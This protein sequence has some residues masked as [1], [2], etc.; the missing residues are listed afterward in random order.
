MPAF[1]HHLTN[2]VSFSQIV[3]S[4]ALPAI[5]LSSAPEVSNSPSGAKYVA[6]F[7]KG[8]SGSVQFASTEDGQVQVSVNLTGLPDYGGP[9][10]YH[11]HEAPVP[12]DGNCTGT[13]KHLN[14][15][16]GSE[17]A[18]AAEDKE[19]GDL[20]GKHGEIDG[21]ELQTTY[22]D[23]YLSLNK[24]DPAYF[25]NLSVVVHLH[26]TTRIACANIT[27]ET[28]SVSTVSDSGAPRLAAGA[29]AG[30][31]VAGLSLLI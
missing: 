4:F 19:V 30:A 29:F 8:V 1:L 3:Q 10:L 21:Q 13:L 5:V 26:N 14:P 15:Y 12:T 2:M 22:I 25:G 11:I 7:S 23:P 28:A 17:T 9:F 20:S 6:E 16:N 27:E 31:V 24:D 18:S